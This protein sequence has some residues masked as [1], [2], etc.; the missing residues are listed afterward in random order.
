MKL[1]TFLLFELRSFRI[2]INERNE[3]F[4]EILGKM[5]ININ[6]VKLILFF[7]EIL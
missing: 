2:D 1:Y 7:S 6:I 5:W 4:W 3:W